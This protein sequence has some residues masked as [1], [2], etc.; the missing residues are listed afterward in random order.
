MC[1]S[2]L[3]RVQY[4]VLFVLSWTRSSVTPYIGGGG[5]GVQEWCIYIIGL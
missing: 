5:G 4:G 3:Q 2:V 1:A